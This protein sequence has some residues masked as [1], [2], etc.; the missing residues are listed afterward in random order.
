MNFQLLGG[1]GVFWSRKHY[2][3]IFDHIF[4]HYITLSITDSISHTIYVGLTIYIVNFFPA[5]KCGK[6]NLLAEEP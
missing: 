6:V 2:F 3:G 4:P 5:N 1:K